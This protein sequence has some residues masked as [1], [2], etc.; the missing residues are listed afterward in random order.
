MP[1]ILVMNGRVMF[2]ASDFLNLYEFNLRDAQT[3]TKEIV[4]DIYMV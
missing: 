1:F 4:M 2:F 3:Q